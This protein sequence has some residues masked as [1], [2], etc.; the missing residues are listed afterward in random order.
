MYSTS[1]LCFDSEF[2]EMWQ[3][4]SESDASSSSPSHCDKQFSS[5]LYTTP[6]R[7]P[8]SW[9]WRCYSWSDSLQSWG[10]EEVVRVSSGRES[11]QTCSRSLWNRASPTSHVEEEHTHWMLKWWW[12]PDGPGYGSLTCAFGQLQG[13]YTTQQTSCNGNDNRRVEDWYGYS[14]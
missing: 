8:W 6:T 10:K 14:A 12:L 4:D 1:A 13:H 2:A 5:H 7:L 9:S 3:V 11:K